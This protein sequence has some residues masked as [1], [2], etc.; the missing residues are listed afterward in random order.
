MKKFLLSV[1]IFLC[2]GINSAF[3]VIDEQY[4]CNISYYNNVNFKGL[5]TDNFDNVE[6]QMHITFYADTK[7]KIFYNSDKNKIENVEFKNNQI[8][9][10]W[11]SSEIP[12]FCFLINRSANTIA[13][14]AFYTLPS[15][16]IGNSITP[17]ATIKSNGNGTCTIKK[18]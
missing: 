3:A 5:E 13:F 14:K 11:N 17:P 9:V 16:V 6:H 8:L 2:F 12:R 7:N 15:R 18:I 4:D 10:N 1:F